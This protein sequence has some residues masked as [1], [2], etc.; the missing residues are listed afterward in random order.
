MV[1]FIFVVSD[2]QISIVRELFKEYASGLGFDLCFQNFDKE[3]AELPGDYASPDGR[4][5]LAVNDGKIAGCVALRKLAVNICEMKR[6]YVKPE[7]RG[8]GIGKKLVKFIIDEAKKIGY[9][10]MKLDTVPAMKE[11]IALYRSMGFYE[12]EAYREN[13]IE[14]AKFME[15][16]LKD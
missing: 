4:L 14:G 11:A 10:Y 6:L 13:P 16:K 9:S 1:D 12:I 7:F 2:E 8:M 5:I 15:L 3:L